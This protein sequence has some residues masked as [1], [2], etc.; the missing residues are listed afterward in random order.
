MDF[1]TPEMAALAVKQGDGYKLDKSHI[2]AVHHFDDIEKYAAMDTTFVE[3]VVE[4]F[5]PKEHLKSWLADE[6]ARDQ[7]V[8]LKGEQVG[9]YYNNKGEK[10]D[11]EY[12]R[13]VCPFL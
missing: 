6:K 11:L 5:T 1:E 2:L 4:E 10:P 3:P 7:F 13:N 8:M 12:S 9:I